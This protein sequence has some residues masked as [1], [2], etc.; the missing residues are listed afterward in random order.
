MPVG[1]REKE[2]NINW[3]TVLVAVLVTLAIIVGLVVVTQNE[4]I[5]EG[6]T[7]SVTGV[8]EL[9]V[10]PD[11]A[12]IYISVETFDESLQDAKD[13]NA[14]IT[15]DIMYDLTIRLRIDEDDIETQNY[16][17]DQRYEW[18]SGKRELVGYDVINKIKVTIWDFDDIGRAVDYAVDNGALVDYLNFELSQEV[19]NSYK[20]TVLKLAAKDAKNKAE[21]IVEGLE[22]KLGELISVD[23]SDYYY[24]PYPVYSYGV[25]E[26]GVTTSI[27]DAVTNIQPRDLDVSATVHVVYEVI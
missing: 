27:Q 8:S 10:D 2:G 1:I 24:R 6:R 26:K 17:I 11:Q 25:D 12:I 7:V 15:D 4:P 21:S 14:E 23:T 20:S 18:T 16:R 3:R 13:E 5:V 22:Q 19:M 9:S